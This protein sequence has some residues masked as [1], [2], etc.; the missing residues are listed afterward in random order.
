MLFSQDTITTKHPK[1]SKGLFQCHLCLY[2][3]KKIIQEQSE[4]E[5]ENL[6]RLKLLVMPLIFSL[7]ITDMGYS[8]NN[9]SWGDAYD[10]K[11]DAIV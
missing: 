9:Y 6:H 8:N 2:S 5:R 1:L 3:I 4:Q 7:I 10:P 11:Y